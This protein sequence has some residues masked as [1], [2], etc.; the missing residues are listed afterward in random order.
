[1]IILYKINN[2]E[3]SRA[4]IG[5][6]QNTRDSLKEIKILFFV[7]ELNNIII[8]KRSQNFQNIFQDLG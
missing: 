8:L 1:M 2:L 3:G 5:L 6:T 4:R 7:N